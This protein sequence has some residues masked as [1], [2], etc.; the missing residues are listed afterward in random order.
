MTTDL[1]PASGSLHIDVWLCPYRDIADPDHIAALRALL[2]DAERAQALRFH[3]AE[4]RLRYMVTRALVRTVLSRY[5]PVAARDW[6]F[7]ANAYGRPAIANPGLAMRIGD[8]NVS[9]TRGLIALAVST[10]GA[11]GIDL[12][13]WQARPVS[14]DMARDFFARPEADALASTPPAHVQARFFEYWTLKESYIKARGLGLSIPLD[15]FAMQLGDAHGVRMAMTS[16]QDDDPARWW[17][18]QF[19]PGPGYLLA[20][21]AERPASGAPPTLG[22]RQTIPLRGDTDCHVTVVR[23]SDAAAA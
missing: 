9:H 21:C 11:L 10:R 23:T 2:S 20:L 18:G 15:R 8:F 22:F 17:F 7:S 3:F 1:D 5:A 16:P 4:D 19:R 12:E 13:D 14:L 6:V